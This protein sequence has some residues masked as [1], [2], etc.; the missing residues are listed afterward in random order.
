MLGDDC[1]SKPKSASEERSLGTFQTPTPESPARVKRY[2]P[3]DVYWLATTDDASRAAAGLTLYSSG[4]GA[5]AVLIDMDG[6]VVHEWSRPYRGVWEKGGAVQ[7]PVPEH[8]I[9]FRKASLLPDGDLLAVYEGAGDTPWGY[10]LVR[11]D[12]ASNVVWKNLERHF[13]HDFDVG[14]DERARRVANQRVAAAVRAA[15]QD[16][17]AAGAAGGA[18]ARRAFDDHAIAG[19]LDR[20][21][22]GVGAAD[23][24]H[25]RAHDGVGVRIERDEAALAFNRG[26]EDL[27][28]ALDVAVGRGQDHF[29]T[30]GLLRNR[31]DGAGVG[32]RS[33]VAQRPLPELRQLF[34]SGREN[35]SPS[36]AGRPPAGRCPR[37]AAWR[38]AARRRTRRAPMPPARNT[39]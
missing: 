18:E 13:H 4:H 12:R 9:Y 1:Q 22:G 27:A 15:D 26:R 14:S 20:A 21:A 39:R 30:R 8:Q 24:D 19:D 11:L 3:S 5:T 23:V 28:A 37:P 33:E 38:R 34:F 32:Y 2:S 25:A 31:L 36:S 16:V 17:A 7:D 29:T 10:G 35:G 6:G